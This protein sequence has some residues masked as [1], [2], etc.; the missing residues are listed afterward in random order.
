M[1][2]MPLLM[3]CYLL[4]YLGLALDGNRPSARRSM[5]IEGSEATARRDARLP[6]AEFGAAE[7]KVIAQGVEERSRGGEVKGMRFA[8][9]LESDYAHIR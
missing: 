4:A 5:A 8:V 7:R 9:D 1:R 6:A 2:L 3:G